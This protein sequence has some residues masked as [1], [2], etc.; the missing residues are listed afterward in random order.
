MAL[1]QLT[2]LLSVP[3]AFGPSFWIAFMLHALVAELW[4]RARPL[5]PEMDQRFHDH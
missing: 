5:L 2:G 4:L 1:F 3:A